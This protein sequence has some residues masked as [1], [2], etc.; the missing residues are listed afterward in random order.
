MALSPEDVLN[1]TFTQT[2]FRRGYDEREV[3]DFLDEVVAEMRRLTKD[4]EDLRGQLN[5]CRQGRG[6]SAMPISAPGMD[7]AELKALQA[8][9]QDLE[10]RNYDLQRLL[11]D[12]K[13]AREAAVRELEQE[14][15]RQA[16]LAQG[17]L[18]KA[19]R[20]ADERIA[21]VTA[22]A[23]EAEREAAE[24]IARAK[25]NAES[26]EREA[27]K[28][29]EA[30]E[31]EARQRAEMA[32][33]DAEIARRDAE[34]A[35][36]DHEVAQRDL[37]DARAQ[38]TNLRSQGVDTNTAEMAAVGGGSA[39]GVIA[40]AQRL[41]DEHVSEGIQKRDALIAEGESR[42][43]DLLAEAQGRHD[44]LMATAQ[45]RHDQLLG[46]GQ[47]RHD[48]LIAEATERHEQ[49]IT[50]ARERS[51]G[52]LHEAQQKKAQILEELG[53]E[54]SILERKIEELRTFERDYRARL[55][56]YIEGQLQELDHS[57][58]EEPKGQKV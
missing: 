23:E 55:R 12:E 48:Q 2:Q 27:S 41:H 35:R 40:L 1:K 36:A 50:E 38:A 11:S 14:R 13:Q 21:T 58:V 46:A 53:R 20:D 17:D 26:A 42:H 47:N 37:T 10:R 45:A 22:R 24:R 16:A 57:G 33:R 7:T 31:S 39:A 56:A 52:M 51:T 8:K 28:R 34:A 44:E 4:G 54:R 43:R 25:S 32:R 6:M 29:A 15:Q 30:A 19:T 18:D 9:H 49:M 5:D 3:D